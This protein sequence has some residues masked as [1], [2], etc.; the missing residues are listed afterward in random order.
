M[1]PSSDDSDG[2]Q[3]IEEP[4]SAEEVQPVKGPYSFGKPTDSWSHW[5]SGYNGEPPSPIVPFTI[6]E[7]VSVPTLTPKKDKKGTKKVKKSMA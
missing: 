7:E 1:V 3:P 2:P 5:Q 4:P 6:E